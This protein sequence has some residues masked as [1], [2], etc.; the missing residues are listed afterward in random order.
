MS[1]TGVFYYA[2]IKSGP[3]VSGRF[4]SAPA[5]IYRVPN[6]LLCLFDS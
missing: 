1:F 3:G 2:L 6:R 5:L 4:Q